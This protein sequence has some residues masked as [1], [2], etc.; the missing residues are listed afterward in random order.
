ME[1][2]GIGVV[3]KRSVNLRLNLD[4]F[5]II[6]GAG[7]S[8]RQLCVVTY[9]EEMDRAGCSISVEGSG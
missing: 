2:G 8:L 3:G 1:M 4:L 9:P 7:A 6:Q 5:Q